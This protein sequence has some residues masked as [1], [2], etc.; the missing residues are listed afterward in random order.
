MATEAQTEGVF[1][2][3]RVLME[4]KDRAKEVALQEAAKKKRTA[5]HYGDVIDEIL[6]EGLTKREKKLGIKKQ[7]PV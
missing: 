3:V 6:E 4:K 1:T 2:H 5:P 7:V